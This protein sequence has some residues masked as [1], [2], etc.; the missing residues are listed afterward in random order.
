VSSQAVSERR[1]VT[2]QLEDI[3]AHIGDWKD[4]L[5]GQTVLSASEVQTRLFDLYGD[6]EDRP[7]LERIKPWLTLTVRREVFSAEELESF[8]DELTTELELPA[9]A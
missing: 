9:P 3:F 2:G 6:L 5:N 7:E 4:R 8:L 1:E